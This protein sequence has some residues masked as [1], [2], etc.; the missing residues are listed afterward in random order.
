MMLL[1]QLFLVLYQAGIRIAANWNPKAKR[2]LRGRKKIWSQLEMALSPGKDKH[3]LWIH[4]ASLGEFEQG[5]PVIETLRVQFPHAFIVLSFFSPSGYEVQKDY[6]HADHV[7]YLPIDGVDN[8]RRF[9]DIVNPQLVIF[10]KYEFWFYYIKELKQRKIP[11]LLVSAIFRAEQPFF[12]WYG[13]FFRKMLSGF[14]HF[15]VQDEASKNLLQPLVPAADITLSGDTRFDRVLEIAKQRE[16]IPLVE[17]FCA[18]TRTIVAGS[19]WKEDE[20]MLANYMKQK[21]GFKL[22]LVPHETNAA[23]IN[24]I[25][26]LFPEAILYSDLLKGVEYKDERVLIINSVGLLSRLYYY[27]RVTYIGGGFTKDGIHNTLEAA[28]YGKPVVFGPNY[29]KYLEAIGLIK[30]G[31]G[32]SFKDEEELS[33]YLD[34]FLKNESAFI[35]SGSASTAFIQYQQGATAKIIHYIQE[36]RLFT[37]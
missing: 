24:R 4:C 10:V 21:P 35:T 30:C 14:H 27:A 16:A 20:E 6:K 36:N 12:L 8:A 22:I 32:I 5:R 25:C 13:G 33:T 26:T 15:F 11:L 9:L 31:G 3:T 19:T 1:Y 29:Q 23:N 7:C 2:W 18:G 17:T 37:N 34:R 28:V